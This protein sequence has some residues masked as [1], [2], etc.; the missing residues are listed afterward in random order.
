[1][2][3]PLQMEHSINVSPPYYLGQPETF[4][5]L[6]VYYK[7]KFFSLKMWATR[8][9]EHKHKYLGASLT[10]GSFSKIKAVDSTLVLMSS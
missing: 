7:S 3:T 10:T 6:T 4:S 8:P 1:M 2:G 5:L 9:Y